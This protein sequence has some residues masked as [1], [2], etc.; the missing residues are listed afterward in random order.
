L[1]VLEKAIL[2]YNQEKYMDY[3]PNFAVLYKN[4]YDLY[5]LPENKS[6]LLFHGWHHIQFV[7]RK[8]IEFAKFL[9]GDVEKVAVASLVHD[10]NY[11]FS[12]KLE[13]E[14]A[15]AQIVKYITKAGYRPE[16]AKEIADLIEDGHLAYR[17]S[18]KL[19]NEAK[20]LADADTLFKA[21]PTT[22]ILFASKFITQNKYDIEKLGHK[23]V[24]EQKPLMDGGAYFYTDFAKKKYLKWAKTNLKMWENVL[25]S[26][27]DKDIREMLNT[28]SKLGII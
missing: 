2:L 5:H 28:A 12:D 26:L 6:K 17:G 4:I 23:V 24:E 21:I 9:D 27:N 16:Y 8:A 7:H 15:R 20:A 10:L 3:S 14:A 22:P 25:E 11:I 13:P 19:S 18:R 1:C